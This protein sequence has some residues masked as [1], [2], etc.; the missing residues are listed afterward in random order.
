MPWMTRDDWLP[1][2]LSAQPVDLD[3]PR[4]GLIEIDTLTS[5][6][7]IYAK[8]GSGT[9]EGTADRSS[10]ASE[11][12]AGSGS[13]KCGCGGRPSADITIVQHLSSDGT[14]GFAEV[15][16]G[17][18]IPQSVLEEHFCN[19]RI[20][21]V[22]FSSEGVPLWHGHSK[23]VATKAQMNALRARYGA[24]GG[25][26]ADM[27]ICDGHHIEP[28]SQG[29]PTNIDNMMLLCW[30]CHQ[31]VHHHG[32]REVPAGRGLYTIEPLERI[33]HGPARAAD[34]PSDHG[35][36][37]P[38]GRRQPQPPSMVKPVVDVTDPAPPPQPEPLFAL[39]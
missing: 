29:G 39:A 14:D 7:S 6:G 11:R 25:C 24:C 38:R 26:D 10:G 21:G 19:A 5:H 33:R 2:G 27:W 28:V 12:A 13:G 31:K 3:Q 15:A 4:R 18:V 37:P 30:S 8:A 36:A 35:P 1:V 23:R 17:D 16:G 32:W 34:P 20:K 22:V 9:S